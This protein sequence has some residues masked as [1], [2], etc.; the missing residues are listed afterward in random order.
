MKDFSARFRKFSAAVER[1]NTTK[2]FLEAA[3]ELSELALDLN[4]QQLLA[5][6]VDSEGKKIGEYAESTKKRKRAK[7]QETSFIT[8][9]DEGN[10]QGRMFLDTKQIPI[11]IGSKDKKTPILKK[12]HGPVLGLTQPNQEG[13][14][15]EVMN[16]YK[17]KVHKQIEVLKDKILL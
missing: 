1:I 15:E 5:E 14:K 4:R 2:L 12:K 16:K 10:F 7:G 3:T 9:Y 11:F 13:F 8:L 6:G 17:D